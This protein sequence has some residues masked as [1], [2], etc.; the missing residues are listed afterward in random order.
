MLRFHRSAKKDLADGTIGN[1][2]LGEYLRENNYSELFID[3][4]II[5]M[6]SA[7][8]S[9]PTGTMLEFPA[10]SFLR[11]LNNHGLLSLTEAPRWKTVVGGSFDYVKKIL[12][13][14][15]GEVFT[16]RAVSKI[17]RGDT[18]V[19]VIDRAGHSERYDKVIIATHAD[20]AYKLLGDPSE[21]E[22][23]LL[24]V[25]EYNKNHTIL[26]SDSC[27]MPANRR[28]WASW[29]FVREKT[30]DQKSSLCLSYHMNNLQG[31]KTKR[32][33]FVTLN[34]TREVK[35]DTIIQQMEYEHPKFT[36]ASMDTQ[37]ELAKLNGKRNTYFCGS[38][39]KYGFH[40][41][42]ATSA[43]EVVKL[44]GMDL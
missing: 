4:H 40:E 44:F 14:L 22:K 39:F 33:F 26:H 32:N 42:A 3:H 12:A 2:T 13:T 43:L 25:W 27:V 38:Y 30:P 41:D 15:K 24:S 6:G 1:V 19:E 35:P 21:D 36:I 34:T 18:T 5:P 37:K 11:F 31:F 29:N 17:L 10:L 28:I 7:V 23:R 20:E 9:T 8:W 16:Q